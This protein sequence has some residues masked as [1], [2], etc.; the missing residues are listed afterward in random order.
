MAVNAEEDEDKPSA[1]SDLAQAV[2]WL[3]AGG[4]IF[5]GSW[6]MDRLANLGVQVFSAPGLLPGVL[7][8]FIILLGVAMLLRAL[9]AGA[10]QARSAKPRAVTDWP[11]VLPPTVLCVAYAAV[12]VGHGMPFWLASWIFVTAMIATLQFRERQQHGELPRLALVALAVG[13]GAGIVVSLI[14]QELFLIR[15]P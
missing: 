12:L 11:R 5:Y 15:L 6:T 13:A 14:F 1:K 2:F 9:Q 7:G 8:I 4:A 3:A 10:L